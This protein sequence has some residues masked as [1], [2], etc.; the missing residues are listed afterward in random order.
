MTEVKPEI[1]VDGAEGPDMA[2]IDE[3]E[4]DT[5][6]YIPGPDQQAWLIQV[7]KDL[8]QAWAQVY[9][10][11]PEDTAIEIGKMR[12]YKPPEGEQDMRKQKIHIHL[13]E[14]LPQHEN[15]LKKYE[16]KVTH[17][18]YSNV[19]V[20]SEKDLPNHRA[21]GPGKNRRLQPNRPSGIPS[22]SERYGRF[23][24]MVT[25]QTALAPPIVH[26]VKA[27]HLEDE[28]YHA[29]MKRLWDA[30]VAPKSR[31]TYI[32]GV[33]RRMHPGMSNLSSFNTFGLS[34]RPGAKGGRKTGKII[35]DKAVRMEK[36][37]LMSALERCFR[38]YKYWPMKALRN[39]LRQPEAWI[40]ENLDEI[41]TLVRS[42]DFAMNWVL[43]PEYANVVKEGDEV[44]E[45]VAKVESGTD[46]TGDEMDGEDDL[47]DFEDVKM[48]GGT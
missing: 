12:V 39:E 43:K 21:A 38:K 42:G 11:A 28:A 19:C 44:K 25:K 16:M 14:H 15:I 24:S 10:E 41:A 20:F 26:V 6:L 36:G 18:T 33:D 40:K 8:W 1:K 17:S 3:F 9:E 23:R 46:G 7:P 27:T 35:K 31:A 29:H 4:E 22:K 30:H 32:E 2:D 45:E 37:D 34:S 5:D 13:A 47:G 48:E